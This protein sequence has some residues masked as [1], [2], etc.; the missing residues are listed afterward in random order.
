MRLVL[1][2]MKSKIR[3]LLCS[4]ELAAAFNSIRCLKLGTLHASFEMQ[5]ENAKN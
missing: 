1:G 5:K 2:E 4:S 3:I